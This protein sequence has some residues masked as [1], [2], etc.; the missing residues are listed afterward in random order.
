M[1]EG[2]LQIATQS[3]TPVL[4]TQNSRKKDLD[5]GKEVCFAYLLQNSQ[6]N[7]RQKKKKNSARYKVNTRLKKTSSRQN[8]ENH[9]FKTNLANSLGAGCDLEDCSLSLSNKRT[10]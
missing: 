3:V 10:M 4:H 7:S 1:K 9:G 2:W 6:N 5:E 8:K